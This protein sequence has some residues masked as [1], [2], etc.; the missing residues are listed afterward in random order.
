MHPVE[1]G[2]RVIVRPAP[3]A[4]CTRYGAAQRDTARRNILV[5]RRV[6]G[7][8][9]HGQPPPPGLGSPRSLPGGA[10][11][12]PLLVACSGSQGRTAG[13]DDGERGVGVGALCGTA[14]FFTGS[15]RLPCS[16]TGRVNVEPSWPRVTV[17]RCYQAPAGAWPVTGPPDP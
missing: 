11:A 15:I 1:G 4:G 9:A 17:G 3:G 10:A 7:H 13:L 5:A 2:E 16:V 14:V 6:H 8:R 12:N